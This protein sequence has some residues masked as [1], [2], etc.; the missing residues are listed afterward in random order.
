MTDFGW[1]VLYGLLGYGS[2]F[3]VLCAVLIA[4]SVAL[5]PISTAKPAEPLD[6]AATGAAA[7]KD[8]PRARG[9][10]RR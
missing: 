2:L 5:F 3:V 7:A 1:A 8:A 6:A 10:V 9:R 4:L